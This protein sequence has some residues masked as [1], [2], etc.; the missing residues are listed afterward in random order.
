MD[1]SDHDLSD[2]VPLLR[3]LSLSMWLT[4]LQLT[5]M[6]TEIA[7]VVRPFNPDK[8]ENMRGLNPEEIAVAN[9]QVSSDLHSETRY[10]YPDQ[11]AQGESL[12]NITAKAQ[13][14]MIVWIVWIKSLDKIRK[15]PCRSPFTSIPRQFESLIHL[16]EAYA[17]MRSSNTVDLI[18]AEEAT[19]RHCATDLLSGKIDVSSVTTGLSDNSRKRCHQEEDGETSK[20]STLLEQDHIADGPKTGKEKAGGRLHVKNDKTFGTAN[21]P[22]D[23]NDLSEVV[24]DELMLPG[25]ILE[26]VSGRK[27]IKSVFNDCIR[28]S[29][30]FPKANK[31]TISGQKKHVEQA[32]NC[33]ASCVIKV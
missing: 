9:P 27:V 16:A 25:K 26:T 11:L 12:I 28:V 22:K 15:G 29:I 32:M 31:V 20:K 8:T 5:Q 3:P 24:T 14:E 30:K 17:N 21:I 13:E 33:F 2:L 18:D 4:L 23:K 6:S 10:E 1:T 7:F 19:R